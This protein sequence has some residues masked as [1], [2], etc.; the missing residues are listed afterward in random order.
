M[1]DDPAAAALTK[2][3][4]FRAAAV[5]AVRMRNVGGNMMLLMRLYFYLF[6]K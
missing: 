3:E 2:E 1:E 5:G 4:D 6:N